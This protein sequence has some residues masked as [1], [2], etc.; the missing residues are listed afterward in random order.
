ML[1]HMI[2]TH[3]MLSNA[4]HIHILVRFFISRLFVHTRSINQKPAF[5][6]TSYFIRDSYLFPC[7]REKKVKRSKKRG[8]EINNKY[9]TI[10]D[11]I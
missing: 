11:S 3:V 9:C 5:S 7:N 10:V 4:L 6:S 2:S 8:K 1:I